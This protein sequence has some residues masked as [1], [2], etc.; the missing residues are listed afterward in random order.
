MKILIEERIE[1]IS[2]YRRQME[3]TIR[4]VGA[5]DLE[6]DALAQNISLIYIGFC[7]E[8]LE[9]LNQLLKEL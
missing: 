4:T 3:A 9:F 7:S 1:R 5:M 2:Q 8:E 6:M